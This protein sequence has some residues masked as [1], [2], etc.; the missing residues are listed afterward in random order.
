MAPSR[1]GKPVTTTAKR[2]AAKAKIQSSDFE[3]DVVISG[4][5]FADVTVKIR[6]LPMA[7]GVHASTGCQLW[8][9]SQVLA[10]E[11]LSRPS[12]LQGKRVVEIG[13][14]CGLLGIVAA[15]LARHTL[16]TD[17]DDEAVRNL[18]HNLQVN[19]PFW[20]A[21]AGVEPRR[22][23]VAQTLDWKEVAKDDFAG[24]P[25]DE[26]ADVVIASDIV[27]GH[28]GDTVAKCFLNILAPEGLIL[29]AAAEDRCSGVMWFKEHLGEAGY[30]IEE[31]KLSGPLGKFRLYECRK[32]LP[33]QAS[34]HWIFEVNRLP[35]DSAR[36]TAQAVASKAESAV[37]GRLVFQHGLHGTRATD[38]QVLVG[39][40][41]SDDNT[42][43]NVWR[44]VGGARFGGI[45]VRDGA[46]MESTNRIGRL[47]QE[48]LIEE[49]ARSGTRIHYRKLSGK[50]P[51][52][53]WV[54]TS[55]KD[56]ELL[57][58]PAKSG[59]RA[60]EGDRAR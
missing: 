26:R 53:G 12:L 35:S 29:L 58:A 23:A 44:V 36:A 13:A 2:P 10:Q 34:Q 41:R 48:S 43:S 49:L 50:G 20:Q 27:Y 60:S 22:E 21:Q 14:G 33:G 45:I 46:D 3:E 51:D 15:S 16:I 24:W 25:S 59:T 8:S 54:S 38:K 55:S 4:A 31:T 1:Q 17:G 28:W 56:G 39:R 19:E 7:D 40:A 47:S 42:A 18:R 5:N 6:E 11:L 9:S 32:T 57:L 52:T 30:D 37:S